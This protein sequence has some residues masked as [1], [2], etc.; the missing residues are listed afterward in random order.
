MHILHLSLHPHTIL[1]YR[2]FSETLIS[3]ESGRES[4][5][6]WNVAEAVFVSLLL[7]PLP[8]SPVLALS[9]CALCQTNRR[10]VF[11]QKQM[12]WR[13]MSAFRV[14]LVTLLMPRIL[15]HESYVAPSELPQKQKLQRS[16][17]LSP[18]NDRVSL[19]WKLFTPL[20]KANSKE[21]TW[22]HDL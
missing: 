15:F 13:S 6:W 19:S 2:T 18:C 1:F 5:R 16:H 9:L 20:P 8:C 14:L 21:V 7:R 12:F 22:T 11:P 4:R 10:E 3:M 17:I